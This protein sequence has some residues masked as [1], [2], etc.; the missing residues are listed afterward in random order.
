M[1]VKIISDG[2]ARGTRVVNADTGEAIGG[3]VGIHWHLTVKGVI[4][5]VTL[6]LL[7]VPVELKGEVKEDPKP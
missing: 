7:K 6:D 3:V 4:A 5:D 2:T 1:R